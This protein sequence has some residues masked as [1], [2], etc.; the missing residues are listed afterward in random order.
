VNTTSGTF[1]TIIFHSWIIMRSTT[2]EP[3]FKIT[4]MQAKT[5]YFYSPYTL[6]LIVPLEYII[7]AVLL[8][9]RMSCYYSARAELLCSHMCYPCKN[10][11]KE[12]SLKSVQ[13]VVKST[14]AVKKLQRYCCKLFYSCR[15]LKVALVWL[16]LH[17]FVFLNSLTLRLAFLLMRKCNNY[18]YKLNRK[19]FFIDS[20]Y[21]I[22]I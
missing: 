2:N 15:L 14:V 12:W 7:F 8:Q 20:F 9:C 17:G 3:N 11:Y 21:E 16:D 5:L 13:T 19:C 10:I 6:S 1:T 18:F 22:M 4:F